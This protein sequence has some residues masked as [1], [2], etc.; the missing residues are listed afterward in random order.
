VKVREE[1]REQAYQQYR[2]AVLAA[3]RRRSASICAS[4]PA[5]RRR[6]A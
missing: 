5:T 4:G 1:D 6:Q 3:L 2:Q